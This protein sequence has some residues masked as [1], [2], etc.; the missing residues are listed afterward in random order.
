MRCNKIKVK[1]KMFISFENLKKFKYNATYNNK[2]NDSYHV[3]VIDKQ[4]NIYKVI[5]T[6]VPT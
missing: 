3:Y 6:N 2:K 1:K 4:F 5:K